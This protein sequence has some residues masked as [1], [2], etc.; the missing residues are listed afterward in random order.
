[1]I[2]NTSFPSKEN[3]ELKQERIEVSFNNMTLNQVS[4]YTSLQQSAE[5]EEATFDEAVQTGF[6]Y[7]REGKASESLFHFARA[8]R[9]REDKPELLP[10]KAEV[11]IAISNVHS[12]RSDPI[13]SIHAL[14]YSLEMLVAYYGP[15]SPPVAVVLQKL[16]N[17][18]ANIRQPETAIQCLCEA[19]A[20]A[21]ASHNVH[22]SSIW[23]ALGKQLLTLG[24]IEDAQTCFDEAK[25]HSHGSSTE[26]SSN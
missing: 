14:Q 6:K 12:F 13:K 7:Y 20:I 18:Y 22:V 19:L 25:E 17:E 16:A 21:L 26:F 9:Q 15:R 11:L 2:R 1:M 24:L 4:S 3:V 8:L 10:V 5:G 23:R